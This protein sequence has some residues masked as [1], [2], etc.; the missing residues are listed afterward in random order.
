MLQYRKLAD[1]IYVFLPL[2]RLLK[3]E[4][5]EEIYAIALKM[6]I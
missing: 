3:K 1:I 5:L 2:P 6:I 4:K